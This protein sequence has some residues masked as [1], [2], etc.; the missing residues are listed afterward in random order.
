MYANEPLASVLSEPVSGEVS[1]LWH[2]RPALLRTHANHPEICKLA[3]QLHT[4]QMQEEQNKH[5]Y[6]DTQTVCKSKNMFNHTG[7]KK[8][9]KQKKHPSN[10]RLSN[11]Q[12]S[13]TWMSDMPLLYWF[14]MTFAA[15]IDYYYFH[16]RL[17]CQ[18]FFDWSASLKYLKLRVTKLPFLN[19]FP[20]ATI[21]QLF[22]WQKINKQLL[23]WSLYRLHFL[24]AGYV[25][26]AAFLCLTLL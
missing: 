19:V 3:L 9:C 6:I 1:K 20:A 14:N 17:I 25:R 2:I 11:P 18:L 12:L 13:L 24:F 5:T 22:D 15:A 26:I 23:W 21:S 7:N 16:Y 8:Q 10:C 4:A